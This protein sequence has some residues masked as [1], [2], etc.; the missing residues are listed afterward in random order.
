MITCLSNKQFT[1]KHG[2]K[3]HGHE[4]GLVRTKTRNETTNRSCNVLSLFAIF[5]EF[6]KQNILA[7]NNLI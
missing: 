1:S 3:R 2:C 4:H 6:N 7:N 5:C